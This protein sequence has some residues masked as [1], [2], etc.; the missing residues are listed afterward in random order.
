MESNGEQ[1]VAE[2]NTSSSATDVNKRD[3]QLSYWCLTWNGYKMERLESVSLIQSVLKNECQWYIMQEEIGE[4][5][6]EHIQGC[7]YFKGGK[8][9]SAL[10]K[11]HWGIHWE[12]TKQISASAYYCSN[13]T[14]RSG[15]IWTHNFTIPMTLTCTVDEPYGW[16]LEVMDIIAQKPNKRDVHWFW[17]PYGNVGKTELCKYLIVHHNALMLTGKSNDMFH[18]VAKFPE[19]R[20]LFLVNVPRSQQDFINYGAIECIKDGLICSGK[21]EGCQIVFDRPHVIVFANMT[22]CLSKMSSDR[23]IIHPLHNEKEDFKNH[24]ES[25][26]L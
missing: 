20:N 24:L 1:I 8:R 3:K 21:Y 4:T 13:N 22:P 17:E 5:G 26:C 14:K 10:K 7:I 19:K 11:Y 25:L 15:K 2:G 12:V 18:M 9:L 23:W 16:Q 6:N